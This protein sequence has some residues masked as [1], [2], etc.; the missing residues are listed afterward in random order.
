[1]KYD[2]HIGQDG[3]QFEGGIISGGI[4]RGE[5]GVPSKKVL[6][7]GGGG[8]GRHRVTQNWVSLPTGTTGEPHLPRFHVGSKPH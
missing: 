8:L 4:E 2:P 5:K 1:M 7:W 3:C 6:E